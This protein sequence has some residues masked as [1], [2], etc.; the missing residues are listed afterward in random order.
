M[1]NQILD[2]TLSKFLKHD[3]ARGQTLAEATSAIRGRLLGKLEAQK[4][5]DWLKEARR[6]ATVRINEPY[7]FGALKTEFP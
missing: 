3:N 5:T 7:R 1:C 4:L 2:F 6:K